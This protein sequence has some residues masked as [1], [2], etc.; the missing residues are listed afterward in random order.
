[1]P[2]AMRSTASTGRAPGIRLGIAASV[3]RLPLVAAA[4][5]TMATCA[6]LGAPISFPPSPLMSALYLVPVNVVTLIVVRAL[7]HREGRWLR[8]LLG[9][10]RRRIGRD[11]AWGLLWLS[12]LYVPFAATIVVVML[13][14]F[15]GDAFDRFER[16]F[17]PALSGTPDA[18]PAVLFTLAV[19]A[20]VLFAPLNAP[21][22]EVLYR[23][24]AQG[25]LACRLPIWAATVIPAAA[26]GLQ[27]VFFAP[28]VPAM[29]VYGLAFFVWGVGAGLIYARQR[30]LMPLVMCHFVV[31]LL[32]SA[33]A[34]AIP[35]LV[36]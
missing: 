1:M 14:L 6:A 26:F 8:D 34:L 16:V 22:E 17:V 23:G 27:H 2:I 25:V 21:A 36:A 24:Y 3:L 5:A 13:M 12:V 9:F 4:F 29:F 19:T 7:V 30:R 31:N 18:A 20:V 35:F 15:G 33:P 11:L 32:T 28:T 10:D